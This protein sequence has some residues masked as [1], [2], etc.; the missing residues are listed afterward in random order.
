MQRSSPV[1]SRK[2]TTIEKATRVHGRGEGCL[3]EVEE[4][5]SV[6]QMRDT[7]VFHRKEP[8]FLVVSQRRGIS[9]DPLA[10]RQAWSARPGWGFHHLM[11]LVGLGQPWGGRDT[12]EAHCCG[13][14]LLLTPRLDLFL[15]V[16]C[17]WVVSQVWQLISTNSVSSPPSQLS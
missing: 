8:S 16:S 13:I 14:G 4:T 3:G 6:W 5:C 11:G 15:R 10:G 17:T 12:P 2:K 1:L 9:W 7:G